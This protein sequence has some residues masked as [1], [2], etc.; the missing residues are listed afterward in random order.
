MPWKSPRRIAGLA[1]LVTIGCGRPAAAPAL[2]YLALGDSYTCGESVAE[3][4]RY[5]VQLAARLKAEGLDVGSPTIVAVTGWTTGDLSAGMDAADLREP[6]ALVTLLIGVND[7][8]RHGT[9]AAFRPAFADLVRRAIGLAGGR[10]A[11][12]VVISIPNWGVMPFAAGSDRAQIGREIDAFNAVARDESATAGVRWVDVTAISREAT[13][14]PALVAED[15]L[16]PSGIQYTIW[17]N[18]MCSTAEAAVKSR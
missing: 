9:S 7:Q 13:T 1:L 17:A 2:H 10:P 8:F 11:H 18:A 3:S 15:G 6:F 12:V 4:E 5:P 14:Q 16:H